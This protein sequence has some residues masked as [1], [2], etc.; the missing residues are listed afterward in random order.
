[1][2]RARS[3]TSLAAVSLL[4]AAVQAAP[5]A[6]ADARGESGHSRKWGPLGELQLT[7]SSE[8]E[9][10]EVTGDPGYHDVRI[11]AN[12]RP[13]HVDY[14]KFHFSD[15][16]DQAAKVDVTLRAGGKSPV[17][18]VNMIGAYGE[19]ITQARTIVRIDVH[20]DAEALGGRP[21]RLKFIGRH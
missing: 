8:L 16:N 21:A 11:V 7:G 2:R 3:L 6:A 13:V 12:G 19:P 10:L 9:V 5:L 1:M 15:G 20:Y 18:D 17:I 14:I 4:C